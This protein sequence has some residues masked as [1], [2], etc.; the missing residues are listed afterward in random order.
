MQKFRDWF[1]ENYEGFPEGKI[2]AEWF[3]EHNL[4]MIV[5]CRCCEMTMALPN[6]FINKKGYLYCPDCAE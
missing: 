4:P 2:S 3:V 6:A 1:E 5:E